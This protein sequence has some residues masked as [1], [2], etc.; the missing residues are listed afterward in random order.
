MLYLEAKYKLVVQLGAAES[1][2]AGVERRSQ[3]MVERANAL[4]VSN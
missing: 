2:S 1:N 3:E 4:R